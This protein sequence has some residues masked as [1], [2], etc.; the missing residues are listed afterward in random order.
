[1]KRR[2]ETAVD[3]LRNTLRPETKYQSNYKYQE[4]VMKRKRDKMT[5]LL[6][7]GLGVRSQDKNGYLTELVLA[8]PKEIEGKN[9]MDDANEVAN[10]DQWFTKK[11]TMPQHEFAMQNSRQL[12]SIVNKTRRYRYVKY[13]EEIDRFDKV[14]NYK[15][16]K[17]KPENLTVTQSKLMAAADDTLIEPKYRIM[18]DQILTE[19]AMTK[20]S[21][22]ISQSQPNL[23]QARESLDD[24]VS[25]KGEDPVKF[26]K[27]IDQICSVYMLE[28]FVASFKSFGDHYSLDD[29]CKKANESKGL[30]K[31]H[32]DVQH[33]K[34]K[35][36]TISQNRYEDIARYEDSLKELNKIRHQLV[37][38]IDLLTRQIIRQNESKKLAMQA[39]QEI[40]KNKMYEES[41]PIKQVRVVKKITLSERN[42][43]RT[44]TLRSQKNRKALDP[45]SGF[46]RGDERPRD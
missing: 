28:K 38:K 43:D 30:L 19:V 32:L 13:I 34:E 45:V 14:F 23:N 37:E 35:I 46:D 39:I 17:K 24:I 9:R 31:R 1:M 22:I 41:K 2:G 10:L 12:S 18:R 36:D 16:F 8:S 33:A 21:R 5:S 3:R 44:A 11:I 25:E 4:E 27:A 20:T 15:P 29:L 42:L 26:Y 6:T 7:E 40:E